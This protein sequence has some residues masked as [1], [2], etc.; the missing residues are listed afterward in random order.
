MDAFPAGLEFLDRLHGR[1]GHALMRLGGTA[2]QG[3][4]LGP[5]YPLVTILVVQPDSQQVSLPSPW[6]LHCAEKVI[7]EP[8]GASG[9]SSDG[10]AAAPASGAASS[11]SQAE[12]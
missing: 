4:V 12:Q 2:D 1:L 11:G 8:G 6:F 10:A 9:F 7:Y 5:G 3:E